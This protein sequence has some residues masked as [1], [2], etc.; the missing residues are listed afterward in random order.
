MNIARFPGRV[1]QFNAYASQQSATRM[2]TLLE[3]DTAIGQLEDEMQDLQHRHRDLFAFASAWAQRYDAIIAGTPDELR[4]SVE[5]RL[6]RVG[7]RWGMMTGM[8]L[9]GQ[10]PVLKRQA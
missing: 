7:V 10:F 8:R 9:T 2:M 4:T 1:I 3:L 5:Q 6:H